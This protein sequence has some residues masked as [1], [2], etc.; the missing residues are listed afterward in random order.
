M[1][2][3]ESLLIRKTKKYINSLGYL[4]YDVPNAGSVMLLKE[5]GDNNH[6]L[7]IIFTG[8][9]RLWEYDRRHFSMAKL[10]PKK[11]EDVEKGIAKYLNNA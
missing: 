1:T 8:R 5:G 3:N 6:Y 10:Y 7:M 11:F 4:Y 2:R 9:N